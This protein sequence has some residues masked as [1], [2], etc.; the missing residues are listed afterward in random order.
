VQTKCQERD[1]AGRIP[2]FSGRRN[3]HQA[4]GRGIC[5]PLC[6]LVFTRDGRQVSFPSKL[7]AGAQ[8]SKICG[9][10]DPEQVEHL[11][12]RH[13]HGTIDCNSKEWRGK[14]NSM[15][16]KLKTDDFET[17]ELTCEMIFLHGRLSFG[18]GQPCQT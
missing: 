14:A 15:R 5:N 8:L 7:A 16:M 4:G 10:N 17:L 11:D 3:P 6:E 2:A 9:W 1:V 12:G 13:A 18:S